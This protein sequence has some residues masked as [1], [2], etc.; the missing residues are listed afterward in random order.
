MQDATLHYTRLH[1]N[2]TYTYNYNYIYTTLDCIYTRLHYTTATRRDPKP[3]LSS[4]VRLTT[5]LDPWGFT[6]GSGWWLSHLPH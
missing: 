4:L 5:N 3:H 2:Y 6:Q 1:C